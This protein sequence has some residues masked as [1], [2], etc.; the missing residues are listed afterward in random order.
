MR[1]V[2]LLAGVG[3]WLATLAGCGGDSSSDP[4]VAGNPSTPAG[5]GSATPGMQGSGSMTS[6]AQG[7]G[8][9]GSGSMT[10]GA[11]GSGSMT[12]GMQGSGSMTSGMQG[13]GSMTS[14]MQGSGSSPNS[15]MDPDAYRR[16]MMAGSV[17]GSQPPGTAP[18]G[19]GSS[20]ATPGSGTSGMMPGNNPQGSSPDSASPAPYGMQGQPGGDPSNSGYPGAGSMPG[21]QPAKPVTLL[22]IADLSFRYGRDQDAINCLYGHA[23]ISDA[24]A[25]KEVL[26]KM[27]WITALKRPALTVRWGIAVE[28]VAPRGYNGSVYPIGTTQNLSVKGAPGGP[29]GGGAPPMGMPDGGMGGGQGNPQLQQLTGELGQKVVT[30]LQ[31]RMARGDFGQVMASLGK[32]PAAGAG[33][34]GPG[35]MG[36]GGMGP[37]GMGPGGMGPGGGM[38]GYS[39]PGGESGMSG[40]GTAS[41][42]PG[43]GAGGFGPSGQP[44]GVPPTA[45]VSLSPGIVM[46]GVVSAKDLREKAQ[47]AGVDAVCVFNVIVTVNP[48]LQTIKNETTIH[49]HDLAQAKELYESKTLNNIQVQIERAD[50]KGDQDPVD[51]ELEALF[52]F[53]DANWHVG[54]LPAGLQAEHVLNRLRALLAEPHENPLPVLAEARMYQTRGLLQDSHYLAA[55]QKLLGE[56]DGTKLATGSREEKLV[57]VGK[58]LPQPP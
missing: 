32:A 40:S 35:G 44:Q 27:G 51:K 58:W 43:S 46:L 6:G 3:V 56:A 39:A 2:F 25:A 1:H 18:S 57:I 50:P 49:V 15:S 5:S 26:D 19:S 33:G 34:M 29:A 36:P 30:Q 20:A 10:P 23:V 14:G 16:Q 55:C 38:P 48:R 47:K 12:S 45:A 11:Q 31:E 4:A 21:Q 52:K 7:S 42:Y 9:E 53:V 17:Q 22:D 28:Y 54:P 37:G 41:G 24:E 8:M 13:S